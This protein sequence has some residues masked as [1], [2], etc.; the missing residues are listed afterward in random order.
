MTE[1]K[2]TNVPEIYRG[3]NSV[4]INGAKELNNPAHIPCMNRKKRNV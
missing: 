1:R 4:A 3:E 2:F